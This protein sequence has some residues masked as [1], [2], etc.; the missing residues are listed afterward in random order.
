[1]PICSGVSVIIPCYRQGLYLRGTIDHLL[2]ESTHR[3]E[4]IVVNDGSDDDT[5]NI[6][7]EY[8]D[9]ITYIHQVNKGLPAARNAGA[10]RATR[11]H[12]LFLDADDRLAS[13]ALERLLG[14]VHRASDIALMGY[15]EF[16]HSESGC[17]AGDCILLTR[18]ASATPFLPA[19]VA[20][21]LLPC[22]CHLLPRQMFVRI[23]GF[24]ET[25]TSLEDWDLWLRA[26]LHGATPSPVA[27]DYAGAYYRQY[28]GSMSTNR[29]R[30]ARNT[31]RVLAKNFTTIAT[32]P[33]FSTSEWGTVLLDAMIRTRRT[34]LLYSLAEE[35]ETLTRL[36]D[37]SRALGCD[38]PTSRIKRMLDATMGLRAERLALTYYKWFTPDVYNRYR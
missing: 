36:I 22:H 21:N 19:L 30:M 4:V 18:Y 14:A 37:E 17:A 34:C 32:H 28:A 9:H 25:L 15:H 13:D 20:S 5:H 31:S 1:M 27:V 38:I 6:A 24:D 3:P 16:T 7:S 10:S 8:I 29:H 23:G 35:V 2:T 26:A 12:L 11:S 33:A